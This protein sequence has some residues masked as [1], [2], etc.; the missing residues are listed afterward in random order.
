LKETSVA[1]LTLYI[2]L[3]LLLNYYNRNIDEGWFSYI[4]S[5][6]TFVEYSIFTYFL[7]VNIKNKNIKSFLF[8]ASIVFIVF[9]TAYN[10]K[11]NFQKIDSLPIG[12][13]TIL[14]I[15]YSFYYLYEQLNDTSNFFIYTKYQFWIII[16]FLIYLAG[17]F[18]IFI[19]AS[20][21]ANDNSFKKYWFITNGFYAVMN[22]LFIIAFCMRAK[23]KKPKKTSLKHS[24]PSLN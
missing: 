4:W 13:E 20:K 2:L 22:I 3:D 16:G 6:F 10:I 11:T 18:F 15:V 19:Y 7:W 23:N 9:T 8:Y 5:T 24:Y 17:S 21:L 14:I 12:I 1:F